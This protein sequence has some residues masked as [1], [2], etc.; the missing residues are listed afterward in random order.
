MVSVQNMESEVSR[1]V[2]TTADQVCSSIDSIRR[3]AWKNPSD[4]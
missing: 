4:M 1:I 3:I 2:M